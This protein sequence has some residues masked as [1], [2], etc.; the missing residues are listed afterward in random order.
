MILKFFD[1]GIT[2]QW[3]LILLF[4]FVLSLLLFDLGFNYFL[5]KIINELQW[6]RFRFNLTSKLLK[7]FF[8]DLCGGEIELQFTLD[9]VGQA[10]VVVI[11]YNVLDVLLAHL[12][13]KTEVIALLVNLHTLDPQEG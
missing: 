4:S 8:F 6:A 3:L 12:E 2:V 10:R 7:C 9:S 5:G 11:L 1:Q 13:C